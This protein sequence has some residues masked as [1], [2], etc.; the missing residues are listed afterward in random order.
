MAELFPPLFL[1]DA[2]GRCVAVQIP[3]ALWERIKEHAVPDCVAASENSVPDP[4]PAEPLD[5]FAEFLQYWDF[6]YPY[7]PAVR[8]PQCGVT[9]EDW[10]VGDERPFRLTNAN[11][12]GLLVFRCHNC[13]T[14]IRQKH[15]RDHVAF[16]FTPTPSP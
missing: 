16:E 9:V 14:T 12:G 2:E 11:L 8:C 4:H 1:T 6:R 3:Y 15:F 10:R 13:N 5:A 7:K